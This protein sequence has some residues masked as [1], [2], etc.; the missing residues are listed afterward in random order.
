[1]EDFANQTKLHDLKLYLFIEQ[2]LES[3]YAI[4]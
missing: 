1:M 4:A 2:W 3:S